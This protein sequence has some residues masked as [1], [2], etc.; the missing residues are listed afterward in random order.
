[1]KFV[2]MDS[3]SHFDSVLRGKIFTS[4]SPFIPSVIPLRSPIKLLLISL[5]E[6][7]SLFLSLSTLSGLK[8]GEEQGTRREDRQIKLESLTRHAGNRRIYLYLRPVCQ[9]GWLL[10]EIPSAF[11]DSFPWFF[12]LHC[13][14]K[15]SAKTNS[16][17]LILSRIS[18]WKLY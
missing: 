5:S 14:E 9:Q 16:L 7:F 17:I 18:T 10:L 3:G 8:V 4:C 6:F 1:M 13:Y 12:L 11:D 2:F 15:F